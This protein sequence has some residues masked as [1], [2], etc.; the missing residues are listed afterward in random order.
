[1]HLSAGMI[2]YSTK[3]RMLKTAIKEIDMY[4]KI[5]RQHDIMGR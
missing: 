1:M 2:Y 5:F 4:E 3:W